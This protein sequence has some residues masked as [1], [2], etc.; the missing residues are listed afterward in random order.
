MRARF[1]RDTADLRAQLLEMDALRREL[2]MAK[3]ELA[4][5]RA[6]AE[7]QPSDRVALQ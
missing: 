3:A 6:L 4:V 5:V 2:A 1:D 7:W